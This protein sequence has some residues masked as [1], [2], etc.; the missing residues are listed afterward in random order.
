[1]MPRFDASQFSAFT[2]GHITP[3]RHGSQLRLPPPASFSILS[4]LIFG[5]FEA[6]QAIIASF[7]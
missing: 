2:A 7:R 5:A 6:F 1:M 4:P 3:L